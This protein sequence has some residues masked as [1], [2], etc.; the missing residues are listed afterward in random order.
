MQMMLIT[1]G[2]FYFS[3]SNATNFYVD[4]IKGNMAGDGSAMNPW[5][6]L[7]EV[8]NS[9]LIETKDVLGTV[10]N[11]GAPIKAGDTVFLRSGYHGFIQIKNAFNNA[12]ITVTAGYNEKPTLS[13]LEVMSAKNWKFSRLT[14]SPVFS[15]TGIKQSSIVTI[16]ENNFLGDTS[17]IY[18]T[19]SNIYSFNESPE[20]LTCTDWAIKA[21]TAV[22]MGRYAKSLYIINNYISNVSFGINIMSQYSRVQSNVISD[23]SMDGIRAVVNN[24]VI[25]DNVI[26]NNYVVNSNHPDGIQ[27]FSFNSQISLA[28][29]SIMGNI[30]LNRDKK[31]NLAADVLSVNSYSGTMQGIGF[32]DGPVT[33]IQIKNNVVMSFNWQGIGLYD[34]TN[35]QIT[36]NTVFTPAQITNAAARVTLG[37]KNTSGNTNNAMM[38]NTAYDYIIQNSIGLVN[39]GNR[40]VTKNDGDLFMN[41]LVSRLTE[42]NTKFG[43]YHPI[44]NKNR[45]DESFISAGIAS[46]F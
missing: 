40:I 24:I 31:I 21:K 12:H 41:N 26:K 18:V 35:G 46:I 22:T 7:E 5:R 16:G 3:I 34:S 2:L 44:A 45:V 14:I 32:F 6:T 28:N 33:N 10:I 9:R 38:N 4:P 20:T 43:K 37:S 23:F 30:I 36:S 17:N 11:Q 19:D 42:I 13:G 29:V 1:V 8:I 15:N 25:E 27:G 39:S